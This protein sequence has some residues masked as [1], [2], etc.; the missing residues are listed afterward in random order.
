MIL[1]PFSSFFLVC[2]GLSNQIIDNS[3]WI[4]WKT[5]TTWEKTRT[6][7]NSLVKKQGKE[8]SFKYEI[9]IL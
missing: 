3:L 6:E 4:D 9:Q 2:V 7:E 1:G 8:S 5:R